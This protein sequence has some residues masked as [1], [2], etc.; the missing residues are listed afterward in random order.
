MEIQV[1]QLVKEGRTTKEIAEL[2]GSS[3]RTVESHR[4]KIRIKLGLK[5]KKVN[6]RSYLSSM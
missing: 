1:A 6:L 5:N 4:E 2:M 3:R